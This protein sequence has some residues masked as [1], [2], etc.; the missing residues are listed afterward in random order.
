M[1]AAGKYFS[2]LRQRL[3]H[4]G[5]FSYPRLAAAYRFGPGTLE[6]AN[7]RIAQLPEPTNRVYRE[8]FSGNL[9]PVETP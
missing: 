7:H 9:A 2:H 1:Q 8:L 5:V 6:E 4:E 3:E